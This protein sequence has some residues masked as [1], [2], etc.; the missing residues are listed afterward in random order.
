MSQPEV[1]EEEQNDVGKR[2]IRGRIREAVSSLRL[3]DD[4]LGELAESLPLP[5]D[6]TEMWE[7]QLPM[8]FLANLYSAVDAVRSD[9]IQDAIDT[10]QRAVRQSDVSLRQQFLRVRRSAFEES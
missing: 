6:V 9:C 8:S 4:E 1:R 2:W 3:L 7:S 10:L 5:L